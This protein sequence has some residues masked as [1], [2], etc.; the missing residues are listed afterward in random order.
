[1]IS[2]KNGAGAKEVL[3]GVLPWLVGAG[4]LVVYGL[5]LNPWVSFHS[6]RTVA[7]LS[8]WLGGPDVTQPLTQASLFLFRYLPAGWVPLAVNI[9]TAICA[10]AV[11]ALLARSVALLPHDLA[12]DELGWK[13][14][15]P[16]IL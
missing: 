12:R 2:E 8:D 10:A 6:L 7:R 3:T 14:Q 11:L 4:S 1:M 5:T 13:E 9:F 15:G 16:S